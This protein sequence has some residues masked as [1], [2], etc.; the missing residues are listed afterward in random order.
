MIL[1]SL[2]MSSIS[3]KIEELRELSQIELGFMKEL[4]MDKCDLTP[5]HLIALVQ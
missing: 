1:A 4:M 5:A 2:D 3:F